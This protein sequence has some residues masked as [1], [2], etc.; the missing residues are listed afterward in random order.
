[1]VKRGPVRVS[2][3]SLFMNETIEARS[4]L[5]PRCYSERQ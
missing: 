5:F 1:M 4:V 2:G 3:A